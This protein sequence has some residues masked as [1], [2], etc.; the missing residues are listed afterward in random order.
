MFNDFGDK[1][2]IFMAASEDKR[3][4]MIFD[5]YAIIKT[6]PRDPKWD[7][8]KKLAIDYNPANIR[9]IRN[10]SLLLAKYAMDKSITAFSYIVKPSEEVQIYAVTKDA[11]LISKIEHP[12]EAVQLAAVKNVQIL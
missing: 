11:R 3:C 6:L 2:T 9:F 10:P 8:Y 5:N 4:D 12:S 1:L 7:I